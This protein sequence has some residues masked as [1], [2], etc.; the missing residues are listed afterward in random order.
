LLVSFSIFEKS[1]I[2]IAI[3]LI[4]ILIITVRKRGS[5]VQ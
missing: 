5:G 4:D 3:V 1:E 2:L